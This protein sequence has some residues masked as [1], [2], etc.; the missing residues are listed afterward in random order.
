MAPLR[1]QPV[2]SST[3]LAGSFPHFPSTPGSTL[4]TSLGLSTLQR[5]QL[6]FNRLTKPGQV[7][8][9]S[10]ECHAGERLRVQSYVPVLPTGGA[11]MTACAVVAQS[12]PYS[13]DMQ[14]LPVK[15]PAGFSAVVAPPPNRLQIPV[16]D[17][18]TKVQYYPGPSIDTRTLVSGRCYVVVWSPSNHMGK[19]TI[20][21]GSR[22]PL[23]WSYWL[24]IP[25]Y[26]WQ[27]RGWF[28]HSRAL[29][30]GLMA[31]TVLVGLLTFLFTRSRRKKKGKDPLSSTE[32]S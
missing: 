14:D 19:Y 18:L 24:Q 28:G 7:H 1:N 5:K 25:R 13:A 22:W 15:L 12:L 23:R 4:A 29:A 2:H 27:I 17:L 31:G 8:V 32:S 20:Q 10:A 3:E 30:Y 6:L 21:I 11:V 16:Q 9:Y 26:W